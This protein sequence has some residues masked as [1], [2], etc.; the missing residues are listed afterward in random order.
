[1]KLFN[2]LINKASIIVSP[3]DCS[4]KTMAEAIN[5]PFKTDPFTEWLLKRLSIMEALAAIKFKTMPIE[6][7]QREWIILNDLKNRCLTRGYSTKKTD[8]TLTIFIENIQISKCVQ[9]ACFQD[10]NTLSTYTVNAMGLASARAIISD[11]ISPQTLLKSIR[12][13]INQVTHFMFDTLHTIQTILDPDELIEPLTLC[14]PKIDRKAIKKS[15]NSI[16][17]HMKKLL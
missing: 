1:M 2:Y 13:Y 5:T 6:D 12:E 15:T 14:F 8:V 9:A 4:A 11:Q 10:W 16:N 3:A 17:E 7:S